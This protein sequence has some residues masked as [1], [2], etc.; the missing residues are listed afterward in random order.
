MTS[1]SIPFDPQVLTELIEQ[2]KFVEAKKI[3]DDVLSE[4]LTSE[5]K[6][7]IYVKVASLYLDISNRINK[8]YLDELNTAVDLLKQT[9]KDQKGSEEKI[10]IA[11]IKENLKHN[12]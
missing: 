1:A 10:K 4:P 7:E 11:E 6:G 9:S 3:I 12:G 5:Q 2:K 8:E